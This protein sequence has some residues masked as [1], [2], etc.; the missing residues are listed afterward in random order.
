MKALTLKKIVI[1]M[2]LAIAI[3]LS[4]QAGPMMGAK[5]YCDRSMQI[6]Q[7]MNKAMHKHD[8]AHRTMRNLNL[9]EAQRDQ[10]FALKHAQAPQMREKAKLARNAQQELRA[11]AQAETFDAERAK[12]LADTSAQA[13]S[14]MMQL[15]AQNQHAMLQILTPEQRQKWQERATGYG[16][17]QPKNQS[18]PRT[19]IN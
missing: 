3:P 9:T 7:S 12:A 6:P 14:E 4:A 17:N 5:D 16:K 11:L 15:R 8:G 13:R 1:T 2:G 10:L 18:L 19:D